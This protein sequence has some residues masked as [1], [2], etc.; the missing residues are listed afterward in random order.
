MK[1]L[2]LLNLTT[3][4][5]LIIANFIAA[6]GI[7]GNSTPK[8]VSHLYDTM[9]TPADFVFSIW[10]F[11]YLSLGVFIVKDFRSRKQRVSEEVRIIGY[12][13]ALTSVFHL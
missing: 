11:I 13:F 7:L 6:S 2:P 9:F 8:D 1:K 4:I 5:I 3:F 10:G 12:W